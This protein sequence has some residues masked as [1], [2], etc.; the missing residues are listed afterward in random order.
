MSTHS[1]I[2]LLYV[3]GDVTEPVRVVEIPRTTEAISGF[4]GNNRIDRWT[5]FIDLGLVAFH[6]HGMNP[7]LGRVTGRL[8][9]GDA[10]VG[11]YSY[12]GGLLG[13]TVES[14]TDEQVAEIMARI[15]EADV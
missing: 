4:L 1:L 3:P 14:V 11:S 9:L 2:R 6:S 10:L 13:E 8:G 5:C 15:A 12:A 7:R